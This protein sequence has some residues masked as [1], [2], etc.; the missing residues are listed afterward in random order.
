MPQF[1]VYRNPNAATRE[2]FPFLLDVQSDLLAEL[3]TRVVAPLAALSSLPARPMTR[4]MPVFRINGADYAMVTPQAAGIPRRLLDEP[5][6]SLSGEREEI[7][8][9][10]DFLLTGY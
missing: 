8:A 2:R 6:T 1:A 3:G 9:A 7:L 5:V 4:L 10:L